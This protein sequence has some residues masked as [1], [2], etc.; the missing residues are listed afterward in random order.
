MTCRKN[1]G[2]PPGSHSES[3]GSDS[4]GRLP[5]TPA[6]AMLQT[7]KAIGSGLLRAVLV[8]AV[9]MTAGQRGAAHAQDSSSVL[10]VPSDSQENRLLHRW[11]GAKVNG[12]PLWLDFFGDSMLVISD[13]VNQFAANYALTPNALV[14]YGDS[15]LMRILATAFNRNRE[16]EDFGERSSFEIRYR[17]SLERL[18]IEADGV[19]IT[20][21]PQSV[22]ARRIEARW[23]ADLPDGHQLEL[24]LDRAGTVRY[25]VSP[26]GSWVWGDWERNAREIT[27]DWNRDSAEVP[28]ETLIWNGA[29]D[30]RGDQIVLENV[31]VGTGTTIFRRIIR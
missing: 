31:G 21:S 16:G 7:M 5:G 15:V 9:I 8:A 22:L 28:E 14:V 26:G 25:R 17:F 24:R 1:S 4:H 10:T 20:M 29:Y 19:T 3:L 27:F 12:L 2:C 18:L 23:I 13:N 6:Q 11:V 30:A